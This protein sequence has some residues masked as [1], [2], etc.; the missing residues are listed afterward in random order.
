M[1]ISKKNVL[2]SILVLGFISCE[3]SSDTQEISEPGFNYPIEIGNKWAYNHT[4]N[5]YNFR[6]DSLSDRRPIM[7]FIYYVEATKDTILKDNNECIIFEQSEPGNRYKSQT[8]YNNEASGFYQ[9]AY[10]P[11]GGSMALPK[12]YEAN[13]IRFAG[14][15]FNN[16]EDLVRSIVNQINFIPDAQDTLHYFN[17]PRPVLVYPLEDEV[18]WLFND[19]ETLMIWKSLI[20]RENVTTPAGTFE[21]YK[22]KWVYEENALFSPENFEFYDFISEK[23]L[24]KRTLEFKDLAITSPE[25]PEPIG[26]YDSSD[27]II[28]TDINF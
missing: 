9:Y 7:D 4:W 25:S 2:I 22:I 6:P 20:G 21:C 3:Y 28:L 8:F 14:K 24:I 26:Y 18:E 16:H 27:E 23:G 15:V 19:D 1:P 13:N 11:S 10:R 12:S 17:T 5:N